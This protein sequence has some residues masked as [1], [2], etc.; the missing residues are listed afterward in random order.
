MFAN[1]TYYSIKLLLHGFPGAYTNNV[2]IYKY[3]KTSTT[4][5]SDISCIVDNHD[6]LYGDFGKINSDIYSDIDGNNITIIDVM[7]D[8][9]W[10]IKIE[11]LIILLRI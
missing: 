11:F 1:N 7:N 8:M 2:L 6:I 3:K 9:L 4:C 10:S 5:W